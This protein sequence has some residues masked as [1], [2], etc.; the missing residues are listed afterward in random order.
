MKTIDNINVPADVLADLEYALQLQ[1][2][3]RRDPNFEDRIGAQTDRI[4]AQ[5]LADHG[6]IN[7]AVDLIREGRDEE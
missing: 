6:V 1:A 7:V 4:R 2:T 3:T 5:I